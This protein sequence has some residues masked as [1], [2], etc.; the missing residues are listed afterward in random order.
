MLF[1]CMTSVMQT[2]SKKPYNAIEEAV[3]WVGQ[4]I[5]FKLFEFCDPLASS[6]R[7]EELKIFVNDARKTM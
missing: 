6:S 1:L 2:A 5:E 3:S 7:E 4:E